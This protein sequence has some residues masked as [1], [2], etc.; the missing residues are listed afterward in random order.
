MTWAHEV[1]FETRSA[2]IVPDEFS[3]RLSDQ[4][5]HI[6][7]SK[8]FQRSP[9]M[10]RLLT[11]L[12]EH[13]LTGNPH[14]PK[15][16]AIA[17]EA[18]GK[19]ADFDPQT[20]SY[21]RVMMGRLRAMI[22]DYYQMR[23]G[24]WRIDIPVGQYGIVLLP[25][26]GSESAEHIEPL[27]TSQPQ[28]EGV[29]GR[30]RLALAAVALAALAFILVIMFGEFGSRPTSPSLVLSP[31][32]A[33]ETPEVS[34]QGASEN[35]ANQ[36]EG[37]L[38]DGF[39]RFSGIRLLSA[40]GAGVGRA[41]YRIKTMVAGAGDQHIV[42]VMLDRTLD[43][44]TVWTEQ[45]SI[46]QSSSS[47]ATFV[48][49]AVARLA[50]DYG[51]IAVD[52]LA[53]NP[54]D[55]SP[56]YPCLS[57]YH[58][59]R[60]LRNAEV[61]PAL[62][63]CIAQSRRLET[64]NADFIEASSF[65][66]FAKDRLK[67]SESVR[68]SARVAADEALSANPKSSKALYSMARSQFYDGK[69]ADGKRTGSSAIDQNP[70]DP[71]L[72]EGYGA[73]LAACLDPDAKRYLQRAM[74]LDPGQAVLARVTL[75]FLALRDRKISDA[76]ELLNGVAPMHRRSPSFQFLSA[77]VLVHSGKPEEGRKVWQK[78]TETLGGTEQTT[79]RQTLEKFLTA[80]SLI[81]I[82]DVEARKYFGPK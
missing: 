44:R 55:F 16:Y 36:I 49:S 39:R 71:D 14:N 17:V 40:G 77:L 29:T 80:S 37:G 35:I 31:T 53:A 18:L 70:Y 67:P 75:A 11:Y 72:A 69:C 5:D 41:N 57:Q 54:Q 48:D 15:A 38:R 45:R 42:T 3:R 21:P 28:E 58:K 52:R 26:D 51:V 65:L 50:R 56:G 68:V 6:L 73:F 8:E 78:L 20:D 79:T 61:L 63:G 24:D 4:L 59:Y 13:R 46:G 19:H 27:A 43:D 9:T 34:G 2:D 33:V 62:E 47:V 76:A 30:R 25:N 64:S 23:P 32:L 10:T 82:A 60:Y 12:V 7:V 66:L 74:A 1:M 22:H 81:E